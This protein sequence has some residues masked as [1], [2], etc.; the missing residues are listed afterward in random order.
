MGFELGPGATSLKSLYGLKQASKQ[1]NVKLTDALIDSG[2]IQSRLDNSLFIERHHENIL[3]V[4]VY[5]DDILV[6]GGELRL[7][8]RTKEELQLSSKIKILES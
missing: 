5:M 6:A 2:F 1:C 3:V 7:I 4:L 8:K